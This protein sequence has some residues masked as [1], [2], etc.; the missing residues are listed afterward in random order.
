[1]SSLT[2]IRGLPGSG[3]STLA[4]QLLASRPNGFHVEADM[5]YINEKGVYVFDA[6]KIHQAHKW[7]QAQAFNALAQGMDVIVSNTSTT[8]KEMKPYL[9]MAK[10]VG[11]IPTVITCTGEYGS[12]HNVP[13]ETLERMRKRFNPDNEGMINHYFNSLDNAPMPV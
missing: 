3:K 1:M 8:Y 7:C 5:F 13:E 6:D 12:I 9:E 10:S 2:I 11:K 4:K